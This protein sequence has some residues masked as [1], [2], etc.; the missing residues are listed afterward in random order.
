MRRDTAAAELFGI[1]PPAASQRDKVVSAAPLCHALLFYLDSSSWPSRITSLM[2]AWLT[3][4]LQEILR[5]FLEWQKPLAV[6][7]VIDEGLERWLDAGDYG[8]GYL[9][10]FALHSIS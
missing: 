1:R 8:L 2:R 5:N 6:F 10:L 4:A 9:T 7:A 3:D